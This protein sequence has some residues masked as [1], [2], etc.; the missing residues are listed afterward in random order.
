MQQRQGEPL[1]D[2]FESWFTSDNDHSTTGVR[3]L[4]TR[5][6]AKRWTSSGSSAAAWVKR[7]CR[8]LEGFRRV[9]KDRLSP[10]RG[11][12][13][14]RAG[15]WRDRT[16]K[17]ERGSELAEGQKCED[18]LAALASAREASAVVS[19]LWEQYSS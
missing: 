4:A 6:R 19:N 16:A 5:L 12:S 9:C 18:A 17:G 11:S 1:Q 15:S 7:K 3:A 13:S 8:S 2:G 10:K 14:W